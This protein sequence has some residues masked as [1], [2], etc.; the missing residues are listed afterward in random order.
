MKKIAILILLTGCIQAQTDKIGDAYGVAAMR[1]IIAREAV[2]DHE[3]LLTELEAQISSPAEQASYDGIVS[4]LQR[5]ENERVAIVA[6]VVAATR[7]NS[8]TSEL[9]QQ[10]ESQLARWRASWTLC[11]EALK[12]NLKHRDGVIPKE[13]NDHSNKEI[14]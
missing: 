4:V 8:M 9:K 5:S 10:E 13:C 11:F 3:P 12:A 7:S 6:P 14:H 1:T 2:R